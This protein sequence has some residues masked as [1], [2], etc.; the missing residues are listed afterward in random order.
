M[1]HPHDRLIAFHVYDGSNHAEPS[2]Q[3]K[4]IKPLYEAECAKALSLRRV[5][6]SRFEGIYRRG[7]ESNEQHIS[8]IVDREE[9]DL[10]CLGSIELA[11]PTKGMYLGSVAMACAKFSDTNVCIVKNYV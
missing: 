10:L 7:G 11:N 8:A 3:Y 2:H 4:N 6:D 9:I 1:A 5:K